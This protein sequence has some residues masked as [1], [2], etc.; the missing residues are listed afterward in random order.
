MAG[1][2]GSLKAERS[3]RGKKT[4]RKKKARPGFNVDLTPLV[5]ITFL[6][7]TFFIFTTTLQEPQ[8]MEMKIPPEA[9]TPV[10][11]RTSELLTIFVKNNDEVVYR[12]ADLPIASVEDDK[13]ID[14]VKNKYSQELA[15]LA[16]S[17]KG[18]DYV[19]AL[20][21]KYNLMQDKR[22]KMIISLQFEDKASYGK[23]VEVLDALNSAEG[24]IT[25]VI[26]NDRTIRDDAEIPEKR[27]RKFTLAPITDDDKAL[28]NL[29]GIA[30][31]GA[32]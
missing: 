1:G 3:Q 29:A 20:S 28:L 19:K 30:E 18:N 6:L 16:V 31:G 17:I 26:G 8:A 27:K 11:V 25:Y 7:L 9:N 5:D 2:S 24:L 32:K 4:H 12:Y 10:D 13:I 21:I 15:A 14:E 23:I 22:N